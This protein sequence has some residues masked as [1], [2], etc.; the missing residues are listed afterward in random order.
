MPESYVKVE[1]R[2]AQAVHAM[3]TRKNPMRSKIAR[4]FQVSV[5]QFRSRLEGKAS[6][7]TVRGLHNR[8]L[9]PD[10]DKAL[11]D[12]FVQLDNSGMPARIRMVEQAA[13]QLLQA[14]ANPS[15]PPPK[16]GIQWFK[17]WLSR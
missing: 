2:I 11:H 3:Q 7:S 9:S 8:K 15:V 10:Q 14:S 5:E 12:Y 6:K 4:E 17:R 16:V 1:K 13:N